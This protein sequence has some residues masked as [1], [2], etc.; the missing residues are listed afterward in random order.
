MEP[1]C[2]LLTPRV[3]SN[4]RDGTWRAFKALELSRLRALS[5]VSRQSRSFILMCVRTSEI[6]SKKSGAGLE[7]EKLYDSHRGVQS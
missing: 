7:I 3:V 1:R 6:R 5:I 2:Y 4:V